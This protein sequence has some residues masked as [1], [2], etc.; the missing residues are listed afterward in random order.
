M[1]LEN[2]KIIPA[3]S[4]YKQ[5][6][7]FI[8][9]TLTYC[10]LLDFQLAELDTVVKDLKQHNKKI[11]VHIDLIK[12]LAPN[13]FGAIYLIQQLKIDGIISTKNS[14]VI[15]AKKRHVIAI[16]RIFLKD[17]LSLDKSLQVVQKVQPDYLEILPA[18]S[19]PILPYVIKTT[20][21]KVIC[22]GLIQSHNEINACLNNGAIGVTTS[23]P[24]LWNQ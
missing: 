17:S 10:V 1:L 15:T 5:L 18:I 16:Q 21:L 13:E 7:Q 12:G 2:Q 9:S 14:A 6:K 3:V 22:G 8:E 24:I 19:T 4:N 11:L 23:N 20:K